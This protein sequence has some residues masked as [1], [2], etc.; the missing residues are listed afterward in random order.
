MVTAARVYGSAVPEDNGFPQKQVD[1]ARECVQAVTRAEQALKEALEARAEAIRV[2]LYAA[3]QDIPDLSEKHMAR[4]IDLPAS[5]FRTD[6]LRMRDWAVDLAPHP[7]GVDVRHTVCVEL[8][9]SG[10]SC[11]RRGR[12]GRSQRDPPPL[13]LARRGV[14]HAGPGDPSAP[15]HGPPGIRGSRPL[16]SS[17]T[18]GS[19]VTCTAGAV[20]IGPSPARPGGTCPGGPPTCRPR[21]RNSCNSTRLSATAAN[22]DSMAARRGPRPGVASARILPVS[23]C[24]I[25]SRPFKVSAAASNFVRTTRSRFAMWWYRAHSTPTAAATPVIRA[26]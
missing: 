21:S 7:V 16:R 1:R 6:R 8:A 2:K 17:P 3:G 15:T 5:T 10:P 19:T 4:L 14:F 25:A 18:P 23:G 20:L 11:T 26:A 12:G 22:V 24:R 9:A 13:D